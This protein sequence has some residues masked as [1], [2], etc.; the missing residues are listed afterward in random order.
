MMQYGKMIAEVA[1]FVDSLAVGLKKSL[2]LIIQNLVNLN[3][4]FRVAV[5]R[6]KLDRRRAHHPRSPV[7]R[8]SSDD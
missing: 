1:D 7:W 2:F 3:A 5:A 6:P 4:G 8:G